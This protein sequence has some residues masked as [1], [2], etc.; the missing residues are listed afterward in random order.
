MA[1]SRSSTASWPSGR[2][3]QSLAPKTRPPI[4]LPAAHTDS[5]VPAAAGWPS[6]TVRPV[7]PTSMTPDQQVNRATML[8]WLPARRAN[9]LAGDSLHRL[10]PFAELIRAHDSGPGVHRD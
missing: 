7:T 2:P 3:G 6:S 4:A 1:T 9:V 10:A 8:R 5:T